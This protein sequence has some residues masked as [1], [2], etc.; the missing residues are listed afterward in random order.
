MQKVKIIS[1]AYSQQPVTLSTTTQEKYD[2]YKNREHAE[3]FVKEIK[4]ETVIVGNSSV[5]SA[6]M[7]YVGYSFTG[8]KLF[9]YKAD[10][11]NVH[12]EDEK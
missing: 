10:S 4:L 7:A 8:K 6:F 11:V 3:T 2:S 5:G 1:E 9:E 12:Y